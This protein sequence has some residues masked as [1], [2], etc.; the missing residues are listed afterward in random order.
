MQL[1]RHK[2][3]SGFVKR[4]GVTRVKRLLLPCQI[5]DQYSN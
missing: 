3:F 2:K 1:F 5:K 4:C